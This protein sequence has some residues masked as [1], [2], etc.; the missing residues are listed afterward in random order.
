[1]ITQFRMRFP[2]GKAK[3][4]TLSYDDGV[5]QDVR[6]IEIMRKNGIKGTFNINS[7]EYPPE[8]RK[9]PQGQIHRRMSL[10]QSLKVYEGEDIEIAVHGTNH[11]FWDSQPAAA[12]M[13]DIINDRRA[14][15]E[16]FGGIIRGAAYP[17]GVFSDNITEILRLA[18]IVYCRTVV[19]SH[20]FDMP[21]DW[22]RLE[23]T[24]HHN[25]EELSALIDEF[26]AD[27]EP[28]REA[29][30][31]YLWGHSYEFERDNNWYVIEE[32]LEK[33]GRRNDVWY[34]TNIEICNY[35]HAFSELVF[36]ADAGVVHNPTATDLWGYDGEKTIKIEAGAT[37]RLK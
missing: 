21:K 22:L 29:K 7:G 6:L 2:N 35:A 25:D 15:E 17:Y 34:A 4:L 20:N 23:S 5:E 10:H 3:A 24:C 16:Q 12:A 37:V 32:A 8:G 36:S 18:G 26:I 14:L 11:P 28:Q 27:K 9:W 33:L 19:S 13:W 31:F 1:M 30:L